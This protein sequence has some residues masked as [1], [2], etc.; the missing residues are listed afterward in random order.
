MANDTR[1]WMVPLWTR[2]EVV[3]WEDIV[4]E[5]DPEQVRDTMIWLDE[6]PPIMNFSFIQDKHIETMTKFFPNMRLE[7]LNASHWRKSFR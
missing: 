2:R 7:A 4:R 5:G 1:N 6:R 3:E